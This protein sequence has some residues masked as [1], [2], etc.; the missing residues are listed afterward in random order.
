MILRKKI[1]LAKE[2][3]KL[4]D[5]ISRKREV[6]ELL[7]QIENLK[8]KIQEDDETNKAII[9]DY[10]S[11]IYDLTSRLNQQNQSRIRN[12]LDLNIKLLKSFSLLSE[13]EKNELKKIPITIDTP[14]P[15][16]IHSAVVQFLIKHGYAVLNNDSIYLSI[17][18]VEFLLLLQNKE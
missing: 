13:I 16:E 1:T 9:N 7:E 5:V 3:I 14:I 2:E 10:K 11:Q 17:K 12:K 15:P 4:Q 8:N 18:G 6:E